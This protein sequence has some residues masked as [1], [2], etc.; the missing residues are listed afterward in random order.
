MVTAFDIVPPTLTANVI[1]LPTGA[2]SGI[3]KFTWNIPTD[4][5][6]NPAKVAGPLAPFRMTDTGDLVVED[7]SRVIAPVAGGLFTGPRPT[8]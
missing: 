5:G 8:Q 7:A 4:P 1:A 3:W 2:L 6:D